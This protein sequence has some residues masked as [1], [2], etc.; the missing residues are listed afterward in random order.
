M[1]TDRNPT[2]APLEL[3]K[4]KV[5]GLADLMEAEGYDTLEE[6]ARDAIMDVRAPGICTA[7]GYTTEMEPDQQA[8]YC[9]EC[10]TNTVKA[11]LI[12]AGL[13]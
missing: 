11:G 7:C 13:I 8:G 4:P 6:L 2:P 3:V 10:Q 1:K 9:E 12:L 5:Y